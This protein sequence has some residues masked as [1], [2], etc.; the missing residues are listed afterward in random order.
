MDVMNRSLTRNIAHTWPLLFVTAAATSLPAQDAAPDSKGDEHRA[1]MLEAYRN[2]STYLATIK[3]H[4]HEQEGRW[5]KVR[6]STF[7]WAFDRAAGRLMVDTPISYLVVDGG[8]LRAR[9]DRYQG[10]HLEIDAPEPLTYQSLAQALGGL[11][12]PDLPD[13]MLVLGQ[14][15]GA[16]EEVQVTTQ[17]P[18]P[19]DPDQQTALVFQSFRFHLLLRLNPQTHL[20]Y[21]A[22][23]RWNPRTM[24][25]PDTD[26]IQFGHQIEIERHNTE[27]PKG[28][29]EFDTSTSKAVP[30]LEQLAGQH[31][32][33][34]KPAPPIELS[35][36]DGRPFDLSTVS[37]RAV[38]VVFWASWYPASE[39]E[40]LLLQRLQAWA[41]QEGLSLRIV[42]VNVKDKRQKVR[43]E[44]ER[45][46]LRLPVL[47]ADDDT[48]VKAYDASQ[49][50]RSVLI[51][52]QRITRVFDEVAGKNTAL[53]RL[54]SQALAGTLAPRQPPGADTELLRPNN[55]PDRDSD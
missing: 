13:L 30:T 9:S 51:V 19:D 29:F 4:V 25:R 12:P 24:N 14:D 43:G 7:R 53:K 39:R 36:L 46:N 17:A 54:V 6:R 27:L 44:I 15:P 38:L 32:L 2:T 28:T 18:Q 55:E 49:L 16:P 8:K 11:R 47:M 1:N 31:P 26:H 3:Y 41:E 40:L 50:P 33:V 23:A 45:M 20:A 21:L 52:D 10:R 5:E 22:I 48:V 34:G 42:A 37:E 35:D